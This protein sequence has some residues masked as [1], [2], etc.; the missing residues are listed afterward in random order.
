MWE[1]REAT[2]DRDVDPLMKWWPRYL[3]DLASWVQADDVAVVVD[4]RAHEMERMGRKSEGWPVATAVPPSWSTSSFWAMSECPG[5][6][7][8]WSWL[9]GSL[10]TNHRRL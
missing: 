5:H 3:G 7:W 6:Q 4:W 8:N 9:V 1:T 10:R 2:G